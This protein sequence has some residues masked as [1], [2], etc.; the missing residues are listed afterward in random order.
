MIVGSE[1]KQIK[2]GQFRTVWSFICDYCQQSFERP[3]KKSRRKK[4]T[5]YCSLVCTNKAQTK[6]G[7]LDIVRRRKFND[8]LGVDYPFQSKEVKEKSRLTC[9]VKYGVDNVQQ[10]ADIKQRS[11]ETFLK[12]LEKK[13]TILGVWTSK[14]ENLFFDFLVTHFGAEVIRQ[15]RVKGSRRPIDFYIV[16]LDTYVQFDGIYWHGLNRQIKQ[17][18]KS[19]KPHDQEICQRWHKDRAQDVWFKSQNLKLVRITDKE[20]CELS[21]EDILR[22]IR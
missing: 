10:V 11:C 14:A 20:F 13:Q 22:K 17:I 5:H 16:Q 19:L 21:S 15:K 9:Q 12:R 7:V 3:E 4:E 1:F 2:T 6:N 8:S 18:E